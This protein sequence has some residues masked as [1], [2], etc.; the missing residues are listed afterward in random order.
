MKRIALLILLLVALSCVKKGTKIVDVSKGYWE[1]GIASWYGDEFKGKKTASGEVFDPNK[2]TGAHKTLPL[3]SIVKVTN[4][5]NGKSIN[6]RIND[7][8]PFVKGRIIDCSKQAAKEL[9][10]Y[11]QGTTK[12]KIILI[13]KGK[14]STRFSPTEVVD[15]QKE[16]V[17]NETFTVQVGAFSDINNAKRFKEKMARMFGDCYIAK[18]KGFYRVRIGHFATN[19]EAEAILSLL[20]KEGIE[21]FITRND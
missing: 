18:F 2:L 15:S 14:L 9:G 11:T 12:V 1:K 10:F 6:L 21:G 19:K 4:L 17:L 8:G 3:G 5:E 16:K 7:R 20:E 13:K